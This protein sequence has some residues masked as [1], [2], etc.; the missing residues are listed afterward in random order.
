MS[1]S[2]DTVTIDLLNK[3]NITNQPETHKKDVYDV[4]PY[5]NN[6]VEMLILTFKFPDTELLKTDMA[7]AYHT[8]EAW[9]NVQVH[10]SNDQPQIS[11]KKDFSNNVTNDMQNQS[12][13]PLD[14]CSINPVDLVNE[15]RM[16]AQALPFKPTV[17]STAHSIG[18]DLWRQL[19]HAQIPVFSGDKRHYQS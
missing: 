11:R 6:K 8:H 13:A 5:T 16:N 7:P 4:P 1:E 2:S 3:L 10:Q 9:E 19:K 15:S 12:G 18:Q 14:Y 17:S